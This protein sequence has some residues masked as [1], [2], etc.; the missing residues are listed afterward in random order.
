[1]PAVLKEMMRHES[2]DT[3]MQYYVGRNAQA[4]ADVIWGAYSAAV[5]NTSGN[6]QAADPVESP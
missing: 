4:T 5:G 3:T 6:K 2:I 1:M